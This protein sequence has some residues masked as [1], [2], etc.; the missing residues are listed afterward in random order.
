MNFLFKLL[1]WALPSQSVDVV[2]RQL[3]VLAKRLA[4]AEAKQHAKAKTVD[5]VIVA[6]QAEREAARAEADRA[7]RVAA[8][9]NDLIN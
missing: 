1:A 6:L 9:I 7:A 4:E 3:G 5:G 8:K 2:V